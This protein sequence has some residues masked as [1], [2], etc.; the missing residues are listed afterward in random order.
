MLQFYIARVA[1]YFVARMVIPA[2]WW[3][4]PTSFLPLIN[5][6]GWWV[7]RALD[8][9]IAAAPKPWGTIAREF[10]WLVD[11]AGDLI[12]WVV[13]WRTAPEVKDHVEVLLK[14]FFT[15]GGWLMVLQIT[16]VIFV[17][18]RVRQWM[19]RRR[20]SRT[21]DCAEQERPAL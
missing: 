21:R 16:L 8:S 12:Q 17:M 14:A 19:R 11:K 1:A 15:P 9:L 10:L 7:R 13:H 18:I 4:W 20:T 3:F 2:V 6:N 5:F